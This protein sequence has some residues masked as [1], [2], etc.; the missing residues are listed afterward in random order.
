MTRTNNS[1]DPRVLKTV[2]IAVLIPPGLS[3]SKVFETLFW[4]LSYSNPLPEWTLGVVKLLW[5]TSYSIGIAWLLIKI[6][7]KPKSNS[8]VSYPTKQDL[9]KPT[10]DASAESIGK[11]VGGVVLFAVLWYGLD[12]YVK[13]DSVDRMYDIQNEVADDFE[14]QYRDVEKYGTA[15]DKC[16]RAGLVAE[17]HL[18]AGNQSAY[19]RW[20]TIERE[21]CRTAGVNR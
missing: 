19:A 3:V 20:K 8:R 18:Q 13:Q 14:R 15:I 12:A 1:I 7:R 16:V 4:D 6:W 17:G 21:D 10:S 11:L 5:F 2:L 9:Q